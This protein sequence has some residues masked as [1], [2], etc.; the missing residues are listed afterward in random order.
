[1]SKVKKKFIFGLIGLILLS[2]IFYQVITIR[3]ELNS[4]NV[5]FHIVK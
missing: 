5:K 3:K 2:M 4:S 1:M